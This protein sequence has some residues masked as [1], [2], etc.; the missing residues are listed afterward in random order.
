MSTGV[1]EVTSNFKKN[2]SKYTFQK[3]YRNNKVL[4]LKQIKHFHTLKDPNPT[5]REES[6]CL[7]GP[8]RA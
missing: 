4:D 5:A 1:Y 2:V 7:C 3:S 8:L 6:A